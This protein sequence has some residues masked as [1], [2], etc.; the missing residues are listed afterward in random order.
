LK[1]KITLVESTSTIRLLSNFLVKKVKKKRLSFQ[2]KVLP[3][4]YF[5]AKFT[6]S[7]VYRK[8]RNGDKAIK[9][10]K[11]CQNVKNAPLKLDIIMERR[12]S[13]Y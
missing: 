10:Q 12:K 2:I 5:L 8:R 13:Q 3:D 4:V 9:R 6:E 11:F 1:K 7:Q